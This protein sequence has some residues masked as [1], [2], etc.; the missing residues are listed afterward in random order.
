MKKKTELISKVKVVIPI[1]YDLGGETKDY[2]KY[3][4]KLKLKYPDLHKVELSLFDFNVSYLWIRDPILILDKQP[5]R[6]NFK[7][8]NYSFTRTIKIYLSQGIISIIL[9]TVMKNVSTFDLIDFYNDYTVERLK[10]L[11]SYLGK[12][13][14]NIE[15]FTQL[16]NE[17]ESDFPNLNF[18]HIV[19]EIR[20]L[21][22]SVIEPKS[23]TYIFHNSRVLF[24]VFDSLSEEELIINS[25]KFYSLLKLTKT[26]NPPTNEVKST[27]IQSMM[28][29]Q[30]KFILT[31]DWASVILLNGDKKFENDAILL[32]DLAQMFWYICQKWIFFLKHV[33]ETKYEEINNLASIKGINQ[34]KY[35]N[36]MDNAI[37]LNSYIA[38]VHFSLLEVKNVDLIFYNPEYCK[39]MR[40]FCEGIGIPNHIKL[41]EDN[42][43]ILSGY[44][45]RLKDTID[46]NLNYSAARQSLKASLSTQFLTAIFSGA[47]GISIATLVKEAGIIKEL[48]TVI[49][50]SILWII[51]AAVSIVANYIIV[52]KRWDA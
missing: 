45:Q 24:F 4:T 15:E 42:L 23:Y 34:I 48:D 46:Q 29:Y 17:D 36:L 12:N 5:I 6:L 25:S 13:S 1:K 16:D 8:K 52:N 43:S 47:V 44:H 27:I 10:E 26:S 30:N 14:Y 37:K 19:D 22:N 39:M 31:G 2:E 20:A 11:K 40:K 18:G 51:I 3:C 28:T 41:V 50:A 32:F 38:A 33:I 9:S 21:S 7:G 35:D 49:L